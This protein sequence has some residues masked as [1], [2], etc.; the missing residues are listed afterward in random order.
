MVYSTA[1]GGTDIIEKGDF[2]DKK[3]PFLFISCLFT[4]FFTPGLR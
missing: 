3:S 1:P 2:C 4:T